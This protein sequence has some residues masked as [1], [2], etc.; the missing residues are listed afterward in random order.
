MRSSLLA[1]APLAASIIITVSLHTSR[2]KDGPGGS[3]GACGDGGRKMNG[4]LS[5]TSQIEASLPGFPA[6]ASLGQPRAARRSPAWLY[7]VCS[8]SLACR[9]APRCTRVEGSNAAYT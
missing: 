7:V 6:A 1:D 8:R 5:V 9:D 4:A 2:G 3:G